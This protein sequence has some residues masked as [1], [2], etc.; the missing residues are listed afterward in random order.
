M[1]L[2]FSNALKSIAS[3]AI[4]F[5]FIFIPNWRL[6]LKE[7]IKNRLFQST[8]IIALFYI[9]SLLVSKNLDYYFI[10]VKEKLLYLFIPITFYCISF[11]SKEKKYGKIIF[12]ILSSIQAI[13]ALNY[14]ILH[15]VETQYLYSIGKVLP[16]IKIQHVQIAVLVAFSIIMLLSLLF[17]KSKKWIKI[18]VLS[19]IFFLFFFLHIFAVRTGLV[20]VYLL[21]ILFLGL[22]LYE[23]KWYKIFLISCVVLVGSLIIFYQN[24]TNLKNKISY[25][26]YDIMQFKNNDN[27]AFQYSDSRRLNSIKIGLEIA[28]KYPIT[29]CGIGDIKDECAKIYTEKYKL[30]NADYYYLPH[31]QYI[32][33]LSCFGYIFGTILILCFCY[34][35]VYFAK[36]KDYL[37]TT[38]F[39]GLIIFG[40]WDAFLGTLFG[41]SIYLLLIG[42][43]LSKNNDSTTYKY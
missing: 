33:F 9:L 16:V 24:S 3:V 1:G 42:I 34:P 4:A 13:Y 43:G 12:G 11:T 8:I 23:L 18:I 29:G 17:T 40:I 38:L 6:E 37:L 26:K 7:L 19:L 15:K 28:N 10:S 30:D 39:T 14:F 31:S 36:H 35:V 2:F 5:S 41:N 25:M 22:K 27:K 32:Y 21:T 20:L